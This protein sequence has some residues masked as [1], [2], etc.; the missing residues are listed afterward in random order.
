[1]YA[2]LAFLFAFFY[3]MTTHNVPDSRILSVYA[4][5]PA[6]FLFLYWAYQLS[7][8]QVTER[9]GTIDRA[10]IIQELGMYLLGIS[11]L[12]TPFFIVGKT[13]E[14]RMG[15]L[16]DIKQITLDMHYMGLPTGEIAEPYDM[17][18]D[19][20]HTS[21]FIAAFNRYATNPINQSLTDFRTKLWESRSKSA[22]FWRTYELERT[23]N[24]ISRV[25][26]AKMKQGWLFKMNTY[27]ISFF[28]LSM[29]LLLLLI[30]MR[31]GFKTLLLTLVAGFVLFTINILTLEKT[32]VDSRI[33]AAVF[34]IEWIGGLCLYFFLKNTPISLAVKRIILSLL[35]L[36][37]PFLLYAGQCLGFNTG[38]VLFST[39][40]L[41]IVLT[42]VLWLFVYAPQMM[43]I[44]AK[45]QV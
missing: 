31:L 38:R 42:F 21:N 43:R 20:L 41:G 11:L 4:A 22:A 36:S 26:Q 45:P 18:L 9:F 17:F 40:I 8:Y 13:L 5:I 16:A 35:L 34:W 23:Q 6:V 37:S 10:F 27:A 30:Y 24:S 1:M 3:P 19:S 14:S 33:C 28:S 32:D 39:I 12:A 29:L 25:Y 44:Q 15:N 7:V 2:L